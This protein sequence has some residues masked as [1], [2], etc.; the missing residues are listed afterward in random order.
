MRNLSL[1]ASGLTTL[2]NANI[3]ATTIDLDENIIYVAAE[4]QSPD[5]EVQVELWKVPHLNPNDMDNPASAEMVTIFTSISSPDGHPVS[6]V[7]S[8]RI[9][10]EVRKIAAIMRG[11]DITMIS[12]DEEDALPEVEGT[13]EPGILA[14]SWSPDETQLALITG[15]D[16]L[17]LMTSSF[18]VLSEAPLQTA[19]FGEDASINVGWGS[20]QTQFHGSLGKTA[21]QARPVS[22]VGSSPDDDSLPRISWRGD[23]AFFVVSSLSPETPNSLRYR[24]LRVYDRQAALQ[25]TS[26]AVPGLEHSLVWRPS[27]NIIVGTQRFGFEGGGAGREGRHDI[28][29]FERNGLRHGEF[30]LRVEDLAVKPGFDAVQL[31]WGYKVRELAW[32]SDSNIL[33]VWIEKHDRDVV[34]LWMTGNYYWYLKH[35][36]AAPS[37]AASVPGRFTSV[38]WHPESP[39]H[40]ILS[41]PSEVIQRVYAGETYSSPSQPPDDSGSVAVIDGSKIFL[42]PFRTQN[43]PPPMSTYQLLVTPSSSSA[44][45]SAVRTPIHASFS[46]EHE[47]LAVLWESGYLE[48]WA[49]HTRLGPGLSK[50]VNPSKTWSGYVQESG[51]IQWRQTSLRSTDSDQSWAVTVLGSGKDKDAVAILEVTESGSIQADVRNLP[52]QNCR[53]VA[54]AESIFET[55]NGEIF[56]YKLKDE[57]PVPLVVFPEFC[58]QTQRVS[59]PSAGQSEAE[60]LFVGL[61]RSGKLY[62]TTE[63]TSSQTIATNANSY[64]VASGFIIFTTT[65]HE[66]IF[67]PLT[68]ICIY[69]EPSD[70]ELKELPIDWPARKVERGSRIV[71]AVPSAM[72]LV[73]QMPRGNLETINPRP[74]VLG[75]VKQ[76][77]D[78]GNYRKAFFSC[79]KHRIDLNVLVDHDQDTFL[80]RVSSFVEQIHEVDHLNLFLTLIGRGSQSQ[81]TIAKICDAIRTELEQRDLTKYV[82]TILT[83][84]VVK[85]PPDH[86]AGLALLLQLRESDP[87]LVEDA[88]KYII[89][90]VDADRL[91]NT[92][93]GMYDFSLVLMIA[94]HAQKDPREYLP[95]L[96]ELRALGKYYQRFRIDDHLRRHESALRNLSLAGPE[97]FNEAVAYVERH[98]LYEPALSIWK[99]TDRY[100]TILEHYGDWLFERREF[101]QAA[102]VFVQAQKSSKAMVAYEK[103]LEWQELFDLAVRS[104]VDPEDITIT[105]YR[106]AE[107]L[108]S[109]KRYADAGR[110]LLDYAQ[111]IRESIIAY[112]QGNFFSEARRIGK[113]D[114]KSELIENIVFPAALESRSQISEDLSEMKEQLRKQVNRLRELRIKKVEEPDAFYGTEDPGLLN[115]DV[116]TDVSM[117]PTAFTRY[118]V[119]PTAT[120]RS[121]KQSSR[122]KRKQERKVGSG[123]KG[124]VD[125][126]EYLLK[127]ITKLVER[128]GSTQDDARSILPHMSQFTDEHREEGQALQLEI[129]NF[130]TELKDALEEVWAKSPL[131]EDGGNPLVDSWASR[132]DEV[133][134]NRRINPIDKVPKPELPR[135]KNWRVK[136]F[137][138]RG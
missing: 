45:V 120:S 65:A 118:T 128:F 34:Q 12:L 67:A 84:H 123:R 54:D 102:A 55:P 96:R 70:G 47:T 64:T 82:N 125:E 138:L 21:A 74:L 60:K 1:I 109:K 24:T 69:L 129:S 8:L 103:A 116:M 79:R 132:M 85:T 100:E 93:L 4:Q 83:A 15:E 115:V 104:E 135:A 92:A 77:L 50:V 78:A 114:E 112:V 30:T 49:L 10:S 38:E 40:L 16:K 107:D 122:S 88:V 11:G 89:F 87:N 37:R 33:A 5:G 22:K 111:N 57:Q 136:T 133:E 99:G 31:R 52:Y 43:V 97:H 131:N 23:G 71:V 44:L 94:Q 35:E 73:L 39:A 124:T 51:E 25:S 3:S 48:L 46:K 29:F 59:L 76:D 75:V 6:Q 58:V 7:V 95:F 106:I 36:I 13:V 20:K 127:S 126:E 105:A 110:V 68:S 56:Q 119:A 86:E 72:S 91:F 61:G 137:D 90:L 117:A 80:K 14:A 2:P 41:T 113:A 121:S 32:S 18:D 9:I 53:I 98:Q 42:T 62:V 28:V 26:E 108:S 19:D 66:A 130:E 134:K 17:I 101:S 81:E 27:G 63:A